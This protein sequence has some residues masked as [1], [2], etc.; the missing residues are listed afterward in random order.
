[1]SALDKCLRVPERKGLRELSLRDVKISK[2]ITVSLFD[3]LEMAPLV[4]LRLH[5][6]DLTEHGVSGSLEYML[7]SAKALEDLELRGCVLKNDSLQTLLTAMREAPQLEL[8]NLCLSNLSPAPMSD[9]CV[10]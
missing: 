8:R 9:E 3:A 2:K 1:M 4:A 5:G 10:T 7:D 6:M